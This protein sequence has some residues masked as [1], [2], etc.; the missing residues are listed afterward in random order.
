M[1]VRCTTK[2]DITETGV[3][4]HFKPSRVPFVDRAGRQIIDLI[5]WNHSR[6]QQRNWET[7]TQLIGLRTQI[8]FSTPTKSGEHWTFEFETEN[9]TVLG[10]DHHPLSLLENDCHGVPMLVGLDET[11]KLEPFLQVNGNGS[12]ISFIVIAVNN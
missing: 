1:R 10:D 3:T 12:N 2:F 8:D 11:S 5:S 4:G 7:L 6:N 9:E